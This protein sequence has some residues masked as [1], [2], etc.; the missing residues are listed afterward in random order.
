MLI[1]VWLFDCWLLLSVFLFV[2]RSCGLHIDVCCCYGRCIV[3]CLLMS[4]VLSVCCMLI[5]VRCLL[6]VVLVIGVHVFSLF[7]FVCGC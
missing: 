6:F 7:V 1:V 5:V 3:C 4:L 2:V